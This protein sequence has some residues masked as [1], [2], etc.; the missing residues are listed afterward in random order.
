MPRTLALI[1]VLQMLW[2]RLAVGQ[3]SDRKLSSGTALGLS[4]AGTLVPVAVGGIM[5]AGA[6]SRA[7]VTF[8]SRG[9][10]RSGAALVMASGIILGPA[11]GYAYAGRPGHALGWSAFRAG[12][13]LVSF[14]PAF[15]LCG[16]DCSQGDPG[17]DAAWLVVATG[18]GLGAGLAVY[19]I[20]RLR[21]S[22]EP[23]PRARATL[24]PF[25]ATGPGLALQVSF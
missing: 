12:L 18:A 23:R 5:W 24:V 17:Y 22:L 10:D 2:A 21:P 1:L 19:D 7:D 4:V 11:L 8:G 9:P 6:R 16:W 20:V 14:A 15:A 3:S 13:V 25:Y